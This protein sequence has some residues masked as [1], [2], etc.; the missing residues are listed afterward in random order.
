M[1]FNVKDVLSSL[2]SSSSPFDEGT[3]EFLSVDLSVAKENLDLAQYKTYE[4]EIRA[5]SDS[6]IVKSVLIK[7]LE[8]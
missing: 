8:I 2:K 7:K 4:L 1:A 6:A 3:G 5:K